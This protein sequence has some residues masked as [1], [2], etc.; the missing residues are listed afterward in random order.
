MAVSVCTYALPTKELPSGLV[1]LQ[2]T[3]AGEFLPSDG[4]AMDSPPWNI[5]GAIAQRVIE[6]FE[7]RKQPAVIDYEH[8]TLLKEQNGQPAPAAA[9]IRGLRWLEGQGLFAVAELTEQARQQIAAKQYLYFSPVF[10]Y[11]QE[12]GEVLAVHM[13]AF[14]NNPAIHGM[15]PMSLMAAA[16]AAFISP[17]VRQPETTTVNPLLK[18][19][20]A[21]LGLPETTTE[22]QAI[23]ALTAAGPLA[24]VQAQATAARQALGLQADATGDAVIAACTSIRTSVQNPDPAK[25]VPVSVVNEL[26]TS[27]VALTAQV[28]ARAI[29][30]LVKPALADGRLL[31]AQEAWARELGKSNVAALSGYLQTAQPIAALTGTQTQGKPPAQQEGALSAEAMAV[32]TAMG[33]TPEQFKAGA[34]AANT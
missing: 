28:N 31:P 26:R 6:R 2:V 9:W 22:P 16:S 7:Q 17:P 10:S 15:A 19:L 1:L 14:T 27:V 24:T 4:R 11:S 23:A 21:H 25:F 29:D 30:D 20:L 34:V 33:L 8:Q 13:G 32:C 3:P 18:A 5:D 12:T